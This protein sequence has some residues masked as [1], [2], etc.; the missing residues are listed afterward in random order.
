MFIRKTFKVLLK[1]FII[2]AENI[3]KTLK[4]VLYKRKF[5]MFSNVASST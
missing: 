3:D 1:E 4:I 5:R 2:I